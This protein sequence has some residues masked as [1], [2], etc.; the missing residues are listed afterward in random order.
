MK[1][2]AEVAITRDE[3]GK[4]SKVCITKEGPYVSGNG[5]KF[6]PVGD[7]KALKNSEQ[8]SDLFIRRK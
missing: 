7:E 6:H 8:G 3:R 5:I 4:V 2:K 1:V